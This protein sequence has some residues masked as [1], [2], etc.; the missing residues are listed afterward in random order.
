MCLQ[1][2]SFH[3]PFCSLL[4]PCCSSLALLYSN[5]SHVSLSIL[6]TEKLFLVSDII[7][8]VSNA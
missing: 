1:T 8:E 7:P 6:V 4:W 5:L 3:L 2:G